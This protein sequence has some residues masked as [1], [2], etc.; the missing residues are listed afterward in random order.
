MWSVL[1]AQ[2]NKKTHK[3]LY[4]VSFNTADTCHVALSTRN[5]RL[6]GHVSSPTANHVASKYS[7]VKASVDIVIQG[8]EI[9]KNTDILSRAL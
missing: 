4:T 9:Q 5:S 6:P 7:K 2:T 1:I 3:A 8:N